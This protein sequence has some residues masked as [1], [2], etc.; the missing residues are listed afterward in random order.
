MTLGGT[1]YP[2]VPSV[3][4]LFQLLREGHRMDKPSNCSLEM[5]VL[6]SNNV[7]LQN[8]DLTCVSVDSVANNKKNKLVEAIIS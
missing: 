3:E 6:I 1:P 8:S 4:K 2:T 5:L 7:L